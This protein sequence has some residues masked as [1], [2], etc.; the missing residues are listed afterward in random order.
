MH[1]P[2]VVAFEIRRPWPEIRKDQHNHPRKLRGAFWYIAGRELYWPGLI[3]V[4]H[5][6]RHGLD[7]GQVCP[8]RT[9]RR[10]PHHWRIQVHSLQHLRRHLLTRCAWCGGKSRRG[11]SVNVGYGWDGSPR[12]PWWQGEKGLFHKDCISVEHAHRTC[13]CSLAD[14][15]PWE[16]TAYDR[17]PYGTCAT[18][19]G[20]RRMSTDTAADYEVHVRTTELMRAIPQGHRDPVVMTQVERLWREHRAQREEKPNA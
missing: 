15:G 14:G 2:M 10:H 13:V 11:D 6:E 16:S 4:W 12:A 7:A 8:S 1:D 17:T 18:C 5:V 3:T 9:W 20:F 19:G